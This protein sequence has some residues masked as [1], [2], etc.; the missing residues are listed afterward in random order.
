MVEDTSGN[1][2]VG[3]PDEYE[4]GY[5]VRR[6]QTKLHR[7]ASEDSARRFDD[8]YNLVYDPAF[9][10]TA[11]QRVKTNAGARTPGVDRVTVT[12][13]ESRVGVEVFLDY[14]R[15]QVKT[16]AFQPVPVRQVM[17]P[18]TSG[19]LRKLGIPTEAA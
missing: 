19:K 17:I 14:V 9:L 8:L 18:K 2:D 12:Y 6:M 11:W 13:I 16:R 3:W 10:L 5:A 15:E 4:A 1:P 7:W